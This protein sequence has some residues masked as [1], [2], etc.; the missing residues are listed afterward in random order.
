MKIYY[1]PPYKR[2]VWDYN[3]ANRDAIKLSI[4]R[5]DWEKAFRNVNIN[6]QVNMFNN[7]ILNIL[8]NYVPNK[9][10]SINDQDPPW[11]NDHIRKKWMKET[12]FT[13]P[14]LKMVKIKQITIN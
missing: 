6:E 12:K 2:L 9:E 1:P 7:T 10:I 11:L 5:F 4:E 14:M 3:K 8:S 13:N